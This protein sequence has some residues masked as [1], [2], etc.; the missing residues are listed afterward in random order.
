MPF[1]ISIFCDFDGTVAAGD[2][3][4]MLLAAFAGPS[5]HEIEAQWEAGAIGSAICMA[6]Q[7]ALMKCSRVA[8]DA[9]LDGVA[10][11]P[12]FP[13]FVAHCQSIG[14]SLTILSDGL[15]YAIARILARARVTSLPIIAN[16]LLFLD[17]ERHAM[18][19]HHIA[20]ACR[21][22]AGTCKCEAA[23][24]LGGAGLSILIGDGRSD[25]CAARAVDFVLAKDALLR[26]CRAQGI[27]HVPFSDFSQV[28]NLLD[29]YLAG[30]RSPERW[31]EKGNGHFTM[32]RVADLAAQNAV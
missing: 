12:A 25:F 6:R 27:A 3:T 14:A 30:G 31:R 21:S 7:V 1:P 19:S 16:R 32:G 15:D 29:N 17:E 18:V 22:G 20:A 5:W 10:I 24:Q 11:D 13:A 9:V 23:A 28:P 8:L 2:V 4:D 26:F